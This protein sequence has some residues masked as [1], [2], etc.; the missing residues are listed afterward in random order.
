VPPGRA[1]EQLGP[2]AHERNR[3]RRAS[4]TTGCTNSETSPP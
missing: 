4:A 2:E 3:R 1:A